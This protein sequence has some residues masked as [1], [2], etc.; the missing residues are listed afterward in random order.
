MTNQFNPSYESVATRSLAN[1]SLQKGSLPVIAHRGASGFAPENTIAAFDLAVE[2]HADYIELDVQMTK[3]GQLVV[4]HDTSINRTSANAPDETVYVRDLSFASLHYYD[5]GAAY[6]S[7]YE[8]ERVP[9]LEDVIKR[10]KGKTKFLIELKSP[11]LYDG[12]EEAIA[13]MLE[14]NELANVLHAEVILQSFNFG[15]VAYLSQLLPHVPLGVL[16]SRS[17]DLTN[18]KLDKICS[19]ADYVNAHY[20]NVTQDDTLVGRIHARGMRIMPWTVRAPGE[21]QPLIRAGVD[22]II[23]DYPN[24]VK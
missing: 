1:P 14:R 11:E 18:R 17:A 15:S 16:T 8:G 22:G 2:M 4:I 24:Y 9:L 3:D 12:I 13:E 23:T 21:V 5:V 20:T 7:V 10:Y 6:D 19:Y